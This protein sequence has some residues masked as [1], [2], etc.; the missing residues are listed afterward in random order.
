MPSITES[1][2]WLGK[3]GQSPLLSGDAGHKPL[4]EVPNP[5]RG[6][7]HNTPKEVLTPFQGCRSQYPEKVPTPPQ[8]GLEIKKKI[9]SPFAT[10]YENLV[11]SSRILIAKLT[12]HN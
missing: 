6:C 2:I 12:N 7:S 8:A 1:L 9:Q 11:A 5:L 4:G 3:G 10:G